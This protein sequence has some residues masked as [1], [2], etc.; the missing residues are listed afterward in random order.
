MCRHARR[1]ELTLKDD[2]YVFDG[3]L[4]PF[5]VKTTSYKLRRANGE[6]VDKPLEIKRTVHGP[7]FANAPMVPSPRCALR[8]AVPECVIVHGLAVTTGCRPA[9][10]ACTR[11]HELAEG[12]A[13]RGQGPSAT[14]LSAGRAVCAAHQ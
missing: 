8:D 9:L 13:V 14:A 7:V 3:K 10:V 1:H 11:R 12:P 6:V 4:R 5:D 2:G